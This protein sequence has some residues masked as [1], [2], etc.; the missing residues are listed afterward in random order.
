MEK[1]KIQYI[2][3]QHLHLYPHYL[4]YLTM[5]K[6]TSLAFGLLLIAIISTHSKASVNP[7]IKPQQQVELHVQWGNNG[8]IAQTQHQIEYILQQQREQQEQK[9]RVRSIQIFRVR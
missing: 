9:D 4:P 2:Y 3:Q 8:S 1:Q 7:K 6:I 5:L